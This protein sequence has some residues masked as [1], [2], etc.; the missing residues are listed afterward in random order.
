[1]RPYL[2]KGHERPLTQLKY[3]AEGDLL[4]SCAKDDKPTLWFA[5]D[6]RRIG[7]FLGHNGAVAT[8]DIS[9]DSSLLLTGSQDWSS[10]LWDVQTGEALF[11]W[12]FKSPARA[13]AFCLGESV[14]AVSTDPFPAVEPT[15]QIIPL[16]RDLDDQTTEPLQIIQG[17]QK[18]IT[19]VSFTDCN[20]T[21]VSAGEDGCVRRWDVETGKLKGEHQIHQGSITDLQMYKDGT[22]FV[23]AGYDGNCHLVDTETLEILKTYNF[24]AHANSAA[25]SPIFD[26]VLVGGGQDAADVTTTASRAGRF[27]ARFFHK[28]FAEEFGQVRGHFGPINAVAFSPDG[29]GFTT[30]GEDGYVRLHHFDNEYLSAR[31]F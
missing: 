4:I 15:I 1:M 2:L 9:I 23:T 8:C 24:G 21:L 20:E 28:I 16:A 13:V 11:T 29:R 17:F 14:F 18:R 12:T 5:E 25:L 27:E 10:K 30:G 26:H 6:G 3:N 7:N 31:F 19:R 22:H